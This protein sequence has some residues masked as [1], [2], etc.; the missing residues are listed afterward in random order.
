ML[1][2]LWVALVGLVV[3]FIARALHPGR[4]TMGFIMT[5]L[6]GIGGSVAATL[7]GQAIGWYREGEAAG[8]I[9]SVIGAVVF[10]IIYGLVTRKSGGGGGSP[11]GGASV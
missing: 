7:I 1:H 11:G 9:A 8:F 5:A 6:L 10:L 3:G 2:W 4:D